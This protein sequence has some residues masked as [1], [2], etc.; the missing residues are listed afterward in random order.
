MEHIKRLERAD[1]EKLYDYNPF[2]KSG[3]GA[4]I[5]DQFGNTLN[6]RKTIENTLYKDQGNPYEIAFTNKN[7]NAYN[8][9]P[10]NLSNNLQ[11]IQFQSNNNITKPNTP[12]QMLPSSF[13][14]NNQSYN[15][16]IINDNQ[17]ISNH[18]ILNPQLYNYQP[19]NPY[20]P[21]YGSNNNSYGQNNLDYNVNYPVGNVKLQVINNKDVSTELNISQLPLKLDHIHP[22]SSIKYDSKV[23][24]AQENLNNSSLSQ[25]NALP[26]VTKPNQQEENEKVKRMQYQN[27]LLLQIEENKRRKEEEK[28]KQWEA[29]KIED[30]KIKDYLEKLNDISKKEQEKRLRRNISSYFSSK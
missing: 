26:S 17:S 30:Q 14:N 13:N 27:L 9:Q 5:K 21:T 11:Y 29:N 18:R 10:N 16:Q 3:A 4:P 19:L 6:A 2:G 15:P 7:M 1:L 22:S 25:K 28:Q 23:I 8:I 12:Q 20:I 24:L